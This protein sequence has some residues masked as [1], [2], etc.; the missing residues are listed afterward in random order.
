MAMAKGLGMHPN[1]SKTIRLCPKK[2]TQ[3][4]QVLGPLGIKHMAMLMVFNDGNHIELVNDDTDTKPQEG[5]FSKWD[6]TL[7]QVPYQD[8]YL[9]ER[10]ETP[11]NGLQP[12]FNIIRPHLEGTF[13]FSAIGSWPYVPLTIFYE[14][15][16]KKFEDVCVKFTDAFLDV[17]L[18]P[19]TDYRFSFVLN[20]R[21]LRGAVIKKGYGDEI[22]L[23]LREQECL[24]HASA[25]GMSAKQV[26]QALHISPNTVKQYIKKI[27]E[28]F[29]SNNLQE[30][31]VECMHR[32]IFGKT[33]FFKPSHSQNF[34]KN[35]PPFGGLCMNK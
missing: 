15:A 17:L 23:S 18:S 34:V 2:M 7:H 11:A 26:A 9:F 6:N 24:W 35:N 27:R 31:M 29:G 8:H 21:K 25:M 28:I 22:H 10:Q 19:T 13:V 12:I 33:S 1:L 5:A 4:C 14:S 16:L 3:V 30:I 20:N 32:G